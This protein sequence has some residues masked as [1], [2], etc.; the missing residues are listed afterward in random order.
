MMARIANDTTASQL[1][2]WVKMTH[3][4]VSVSLRIRT[5]HVDSIPF[6]ELG[7]VLPILE[8]SWRVAI[9]STSTL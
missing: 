8:I 9:D 6:G 4:L 3:T 5:L 1:N 2:L 7:K